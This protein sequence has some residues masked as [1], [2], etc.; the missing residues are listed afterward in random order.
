MYRTTV[1]TVLG[2]I[3]ILLLSASSSRAEI[4][5]CSLPDGSMLYTD[6]PRKEGSCLVHEP[7]SELVYAPPQVW[8]DPPARQPVRSLQPYTEAPDQVTRPDD[9]AEYYGAPSDNFWEDDQTSMYSPF[10]YYGVPY[11]RVNQHPGFPDKR[12]HSRPGTP[13]GSTS[14][15]PEASAPSPEGSPRVGSE[16]SHRRSSSTQ[17][18]PYIV[19]PVGPY[20][21]EG[22]PVTGSSRN[23]QE[24]AP[25]IAPPV[26][27]YYREGAAG[28]GSAST[29]HESAPYIVPPTSSREGRR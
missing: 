1:F 23:S 17:S 3:L 21:R 9:T 18:A 28:T 20:Y 14:P 8:T 7:T 29:P 27:S 26:G 25:Y 16:A 10:Y 2:L 11:P 6:K 24:T 19:P 5:I 15:K 4:W 22:S 13:S 12:R